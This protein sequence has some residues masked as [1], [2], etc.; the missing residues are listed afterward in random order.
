MAK[1]N[2]KGKGNG[3]GNGAVVI[4]IPAQAGNF[5]VTPFL[6]GYDFGSGKWYTILEGAQITAG[7]A[8]Q[9]LK[10]GSDVGDVAT[11]S[12]NDQLPYMWRVRMEHGDDTAIIYSVSYEMT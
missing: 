6:E 7:N 5:D 2:G 3:N 12:A 11:V 8:K 4:D 1:G 10:I 9:R